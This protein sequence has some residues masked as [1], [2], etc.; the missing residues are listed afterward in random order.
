[1][2][3]VGQDLAP[4]PGLRVV[5]LARTWLLTWVFFSQALARSQVLARAWLLA[6]VFT[7]C[8]DPAMAPEGVSE[9]IKPYGRDILMRQNFELVEVAVSFFYKPLI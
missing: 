9:G 3:N 7:P 6:R 4:G 1:M 8:G 2:Y 5:T